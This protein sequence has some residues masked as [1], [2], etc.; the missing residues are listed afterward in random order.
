MMHVSS[1]STF[2]YHRPHAAGYRLPFRLRWVALGIMVGLGATAYMAV[3]T[4]MPATKATADLSSHPPALV[5]T[6]Q[7][8]IAEPSQTSTSTSY[9]IQRGDTLSEIL[10]QHGFDYATLNAVLA[11]D[12]ELLAL[13]ILRPGTRLRFARDTESGSLLSLSLIVRPGREIHYHRTVDNYFEFEEV[14]EPSQWHAQVVSASIQGSFYTSARHAGLTDRE[15]FQAQR[16]LEEQVNFRCDLRAG[17]RF[18]IVLGRELME[19]GPTGRTRVEALRVQVGSRT[20]SAFLHEDGNYYNEHGESLTR[21]FLRYPMQGNYRVSSPFNL[22]RLHPVTRRIAPHHG[23]DFA[24]PIG[25]PVLSIG[26]GIVSRVG[27]HPYAGKYLEIDHPGSF[28]TR[29]L[30]LHRIDVRQGQRVSRGD[31]VALSGN[32]GRTTGPHLHFELHINDRPVDPLTADLPTAKQ[33]PDDER[34]IFNR[35]MTTLVAA[36]TASQFQRATE[37]PLLSARNVPRSDTYAVDRSGG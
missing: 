21:A 4:P 29:Y 36:M 28:S 25:T 8:D 6:A 12:Q 2:T 24:M 30:H 26:D 9:K 31:R 15:I 23:V 37:S 32:T 16:I 19:A 27:N 11:A 10:T 3:T 22:R 13:D 20:Q 33:V 18:E 7:S 34:P 35:R 1:D 14:I 17:N 5:D